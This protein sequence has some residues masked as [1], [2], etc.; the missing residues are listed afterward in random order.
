MYDR[1]T[2]LLYALLTLLAVEIAIDTIVVGPIVAHQK[3]KYLCLY[4]AHV[5][6]SRG[7]P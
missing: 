2:P 6:E 7:E 5:A 3:S 1:K 4:R